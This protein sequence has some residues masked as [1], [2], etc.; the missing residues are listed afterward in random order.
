MAAR[1]YVYEEGMAE[2]ATVRV[3]V[4]GSPRRSTWRANGCRTSTLPGYFVGEVGALLVD[5]ADGDLVAV[6][7]STVRVVGDP[8]AVL[9]RPTP[10]SR[11]SWPA[12]SPAACTA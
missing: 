6:E 11:W 1:A 4:D 9:R 2:H 7:P 12:S 5:P 3:L 8:R 10:S